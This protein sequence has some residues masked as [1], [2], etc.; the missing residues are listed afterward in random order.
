ML[1]DRQLLR[2]Y[3]DDGSEAAFAELVARYLN[4]VY[5]A[6]VRRTGGDA[7]LAQDAAQLVF[8]DLARKAGALPK[9]VVLAGW[10]YRATHFATAQLLRAEHR[11]QQ[12]E[13]EAVAMNALETEPM[14][15]WEQIRP[16]LD[17]ALDR[18]NDR[19][20]NAVLIR[21]FERRTLAETGRAL[22][23]SE[24]ATRKRINRVLDKLRAYLSRRGVTTT[25]AALAA[26]IS[27]NGVQAAPA[28]LAAGLT[29][30][31]LAGAAAGTGQTLTLFKLMSIAKLK[32]GIVG[33][34]VICSATATMV[35]QQKAE[36][37]I[38]E[39]DASLRKQSAQLAA[40]KEANNGLSNFVVQASNRNNVEA[41]EQARAEADDLRLRT[42]DLAALQNEQRRLL[43][44]LTRLRADL[45]GS[46]TGDYNLGLEDQAGR[47]FLIANEDYCLKLDQAFKEYARNHQ[48][49][50]PTNM[51]DLA[52]F[53]SADA[54]ADTNF[55][56]SQFEIVYHGA[57]DD[58][59]GNKY[60]HPGKIIL[61]RERQPWSSPDGRQVKFYEMIQGQK[62]FVSPP[63]GNFAAWEDQ[64]IVPST[65]PDP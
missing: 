12:R 22:G 56:L 50:Y 49:A 9:D 10:L 1:N 34:I 19:D 40:L 8:T 17:E 5:S 2:Q 14:A 20:R 27:A 28:G 52:P 38:K 25:V 43:T 65:A 57:A 47:T 45:L 62:W 15:D 54:R 59:F 4:F 23:A 41:L 21:F 42:N 46:N 44:A 29:S 18:L 64:H 24:D 6:A 37:R 39:M 33:A 26:A 7:H 61:Y 11:R 58:I 51:E 35:I 53:L 60:A 55:A 32:L 30:G 63:D 3:A 16:L 48:N 13:R 36:G 31:A